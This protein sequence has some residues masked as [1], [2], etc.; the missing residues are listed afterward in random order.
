VAAR[1]EES[2][3][4]ATFAAERTHSSY[5]DD[6]LHQQGREGKVTTVYRKK[7][8]IHIERI[9]REK[10]NG[11]SCAVAL[12]RRRGACVDGRWQKRVAR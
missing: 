2:A 10:V 7:W 9:T 4:A 5:R 6:Q 11:E 1:V 8:V 3:S 12:R